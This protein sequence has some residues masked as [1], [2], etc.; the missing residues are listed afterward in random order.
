MDIGALAN[1]AT[2]IAVVIGLIFGILEVRQARRDREERAAFEVAHAIMTSHWIDSAPLV[3]SMDDSISPAELKQDA[4]LLQAVHCVAFV[5]EAMGYAV[6]T[7]VVP[8][9][10]VNELVGGS[11]RVAWRKL[12]PYAEYERN[13]TG[14]PKSWEWFQWL[15]ET[16]DERHGTL[17]DQTGAYAL[18]RRGRA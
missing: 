5:L 7:G 10:T 6:Y 3:R 11:V 12:K 13:M 9:R 18:H 14:S 8:L 4:R 1:I 16:L 2:A 15:A 17:R